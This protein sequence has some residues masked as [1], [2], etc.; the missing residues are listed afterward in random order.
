MLNSLP[1]DNSSKF[2][3]D[4]LLFDFLNTNYKQIFRFNMEITQEAIKPTVT[5]DLPLAYQRVLEGEFAG[6][7]SAL[8]YTQ[9]NR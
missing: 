7:R 5:Y 8:F 1:C 4:N 2:K 6:R 9:K 3:G